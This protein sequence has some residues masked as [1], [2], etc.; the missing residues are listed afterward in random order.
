MVTEFVVGARSHE[1]NP[2]AENLLV[3]TWD[4]G[5]MVNTGRQSAFG[6][7]LFAGVNGGGTRLGVKA[8]YR[9]WLTRTVALDLSPGVLLA[10]STSSGLAQ[11]RSPGFTGH[12]GF[13]WKDWVGATVQFEAV[14]FA[15][16]ATGTSGSDASLASGIRFGSYPGVVTGAA[17]LGVVI[18]YVIIAASAG[19]T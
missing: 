14:R 17:A 8:R 16:A 4:L 6:G 11:F 10:G 3:A 13:T 12:V 7:A 2:L 1:S 19:I 15:D 9:R 5:M 18:L